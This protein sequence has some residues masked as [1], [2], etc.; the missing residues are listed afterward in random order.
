MRDR[1]LLDTGNEVGRNWEELRERK[2]IRVN[3]MRKKSLS[4]KRGKRK[5]N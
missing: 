1:K 4:N 2:L 5:D 3:F